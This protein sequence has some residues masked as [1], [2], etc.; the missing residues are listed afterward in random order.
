MSIYKFFVLKSITKIVLFQLRTKK[1]KMSE[2][3]IRALEIEHND[4]RSFDSIAVCRLHSECMHSRNEMV[5]DSV[6]HLYRRVTKTSVDARSFT[7]LCGCATESAPQISNH[8]T[9]CNIQFCTQTLT[10]FC[11]PLSVSSRR[12]IYIWLCTCRHRLPFYYALLIV[13]D[14]TS[15]YI[16]V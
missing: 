14:S 8:A 15:L 16:K 11:L 1:K 13:I 12:N 4:R 7:W 5:P 10:A 2:C 6:L 3:F 9:I